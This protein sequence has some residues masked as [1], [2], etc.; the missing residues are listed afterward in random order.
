M[1]HGRLSGRLRIFAEEIPHTSGCLSQHLATFLEKAEKVYFNDIFHSAP[2]IQNM[3]I[4]QAI[5]TKI[6]EIFYTLFLIL[7]LQK[8]GVYFTLTAHRSSHQHIS[9]ASTTYG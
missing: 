8:S 7:S 1:H 3:I 5:N 6:N 2:Y 4:Q 9:R